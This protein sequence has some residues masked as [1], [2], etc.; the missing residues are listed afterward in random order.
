MDRYETR[1]PIKHMSLFP[2]RQTVY[3]VVYIN[4]LHLH[5]ASVVDQQG[6][7][8]IAG[9]FTNRADANRYID[10]LDSERT[11]MRRYMIHEAHLDPPPPQSHHTFHPEI[12]S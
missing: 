7:I 11:Y 3:V 8:E 4:R 5:I 6:D 12:Y 2:H 9:V 1:S 10:A